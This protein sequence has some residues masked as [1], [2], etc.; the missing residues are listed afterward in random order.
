MDKIDN[1][2]NYYIDR[3]AKEQR[4]CVLSVE[5]QSL[6]DGEQKKQCYET[7]KVLLIEL[8][9]VVALSNI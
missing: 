9:G 1:G 2:V 4:I 5:Y 7:L 6:E 8:Y 3:Y